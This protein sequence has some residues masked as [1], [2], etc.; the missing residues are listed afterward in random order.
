[1]AACEHGDDELLDYVIL[2]H[3][4]FPHLAS[5]FSIRLDEQRGCGFVV[6]RFGSGSGWV[7]GGG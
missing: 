1:M 3:D 7:C 5:D 4:E 2:A 6:D